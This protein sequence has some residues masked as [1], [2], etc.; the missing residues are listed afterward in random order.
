MQILKP[1]SE[2]DTINLIP[3]GNSNPLEY[4]TLQPDHLED[5]IEKGAFV[6]ESENVFDLREQNISNDKNLRLQVDEKHRGEVTQ[7]AQNTIQEL[8]LKNVDFTKEERDQISALAEYEPKSEPWV[9]LEKQY[10]EKAVAVLTA[11]GGHEDLIDLFQTDF[12]TAGAIYDTVVEH[13]LKAQIHYSLQQELDS[14]WGERSFLNK[15]T[16]FGKTLVPLWSA[17]SLRNVT[18][19]IDTSI[20][21][22]DNL[23]EQVDAL[24][25]ISDPA[26]YKKTLTRVLNDIAE[27]SPLDA[28][29]FLAVLQNNDASEAMVDNIFGV[30]D[31]SGVPVGAVKGAKA[32]GKALG[33]YRKVRDIKKVAES[34]GLVEEARALNVNQQ[35]KDSAGSGS[36]KIADKVDSMND[37]VVSA[38]NITERAPEGD[39]NLTNAQAT[40]ITNRLKETHGN[41][42]DL[43][44]NTR[45][46]ERF[47]DPS[48]ITGTARV[49]REF[50]ARNLT[51]TGKD[52]ILDFDEVLD[53]IRPEGRDVNVYSA[54]IRLGNT[55]GDLFMDATHAQQNADEL[56]G[57]RG[58]DYSIRNTPNGSYIEVIRDFDETLEEVRD[59]FLTE[60]VKVNSSIVDMVFGAL[61]NPDIFLGTAT[62]GARKRALLAQTQYAKVLSEAMKPLAKMAKG[63]FNKTKARQFEA[64]LISNRDADDLVQTGVDSVSSKGRGRFVSAGEMEQ[65]YLNNY[66]R[67]PTELE[68]EAYETYKLLNDFDWV[69][70]NHQVY[71]DKSRLGV[72]EYELDIPIDPTTTAGSPS[73]EGK[74]IHAL[75]EHVKEEGTVVQYTPDAAGPHHILLDTNSLGTRAAVD[76][77]LQN[78][79]KLIQITN[80]M[81]KPLQ[82]I[83]GVDEPVEFILARNVK[84]SR[85]NPVQVPYRPGGHIKYLN[86][87]YVKQAN[88]G[89]YSRTGD[90]RRRAYYEGDTAILPAETISQAKYYAGL[91]D[92]YRRLLL[93]GDE[94]GAREIA[95]KLPKSHDDLKKMFIDP[96]GNKTVL[97]INSPIMATKAG[98]RIGA[99]VARGVY[100]ADD[101]EFKNAIESDFNDFEKSVDKTFMGERNQNLDTFLNEGS[102]SNPLI[103]A[104]E[105][106]LM[107]P[108]QVLQESLVS[109]S[110]HRFFD[111]VRTH[112][113]EAYLANYRGLLK[114]DMQAE[115]GRNPLTVLYH[116]APYRNT[117]DA[118]QIKMAEHFRKATIRF[119]GAQDAIN[120]V[121][122]TVKM[123]VLDSI[124]RNLGEKA[125]AKMVAPLES[126]HNDPFTFTRSFAFHTKLGLFNP[127]QLFLQSQT[128]AHAVAIAGVKNGTNGVANAFLMRAAYTTTDPANL[129]R[130]ASMATK[131]GYRSKEDFLESWK[132]LKDNGFFHVGAESAWKQDFDSPSLLNGFGSRFLDAGTLFFR[133]GERMTRAT[134]WNAAY[135]EWR[136]ANKFKKLT[137]FD[138]ARIQ[139]RADLMSGNMTRASNSALQ[140]GVFATVTQFWSY[141]AR[142]NE[143]LLSRQLTGAEKLRVLGMYSAL[144]GL[145]TTAATLLPYSLFG[146]WDPYDEFKKATIARGIELDEGWEIALGKGLESLVIQFVTGT[147]NNAPER[148]GPGANQALLDLVDGETNI[149]ELMIGAGGQI[150]MDWTKTFHPFLAAGMTMFDKNLDNYPITLA[151]VNRV[152]TVVSSWNNVTKAWAA[153]NTQRYISANETYVGD[154]SLQDG[155][156]NFFFGVSPDEIPDAYRIDDV[157]KARV[158]GQK[159]IRREAL[160]N[161]RLALKSD[162]QED[163]DLYLDRNK[164]LFIMGGF[165]PRQWS[166]LL[167]DAIKGESNSLN[168]QKL[169]A[170]AKEFLKREAISRSREGNR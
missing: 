112:S 56:Y 24:Q 74:A 88:V 13:A 89:V 57:L 167:R 11:M 10:T 101:I 46:V 83:I 107:A 67:V 38:L 36:A 121:A 27:D 159:W 69:M 58:T 32:L 91:L 149:F 142:I 45:F 165:T 78:G 63:P 132:L 104:S 100:K 152:G 28:H 105:P 62:Q 130:L 139:N 76:E 126:I 108:M 134:A 103:K 102:E 136:N 106:R 29:R 86:K 122:D 64:F 44:G 50:M 161:F 143:Q 80:P 147:P 155:I 153:F 54:K 30:L 124:Y 53:I 39:I 71:R 40:R 154:M 42:K 110:R 117:A 37:S 26:E 41:L 145:P 109:A 158:E 66:N 146:T 51:Q 127:V 82:G 92:D 33:K 8:M 156:A 25:S 17:L 75:P 1:K 116:P 114:D 79:Y 43:L 72:M 128:M 150:F 120:T 60:G 55:D 94:I 68:F 12:Q 85:L 151:D 144:Y 73:F 15:A 6:L 47:S 140:N 5:R 129:D 48:V 4:S 7:Q 99:E 16:Q 164:T 119:L 162:T 135:L 168:K 95:G 138:L 166:S 77:A 148:F 19:D 131:W 49:M 170:L 96:N 61:R 93:T 70:R 133:E 123:K 20:L 125:V 22:G 157:A 35:I 9:A 97:D 52:A 2:G 65:Y 111:D 21:P 87:F 115:V 81:N 163:I 23:N 31:V 160:R 34:Q 14:R 113:V 18:V 118:E 169:D 84:E 3:G 98:D 141:A 90:S 59:I 137:N